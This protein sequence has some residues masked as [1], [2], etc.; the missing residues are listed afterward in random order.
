MLPLLLVAAAVALHPATAHAGRRPYFW[1]YDTEVLPERGA[2]IEMWMTEKFLGNGSDQ[3]QVWTAPIIGLTDRI[4]LALPFEWTYWESKK[5]T[6]YDWYGAEVRWRLTDPDRE[7]SGPFSMLVRA[8]I[9]R[10]VRVR[11]E[12]RFE[13]NVVATYEYNARCKATADVGYIFL[14]NATN[15]TLTYA[16][17]TSCRAIGDLRVGAEIFGEKFVV[18]PLFQGD[19]TMAGPNIALTHGRTWLAGGILFGVTANAPVA[20]SRLIW[21]ISF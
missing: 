14:K 5:A 17:A 16:A 1:T 15:Q 8:G 20:M 4:E 19:F 21:A 10:P 6:Q 9:H 18:N 11:P 12:L 7:Q 3:A 2:E 13:S